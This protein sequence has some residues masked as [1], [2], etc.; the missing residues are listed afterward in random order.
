MLVKIALA[1]SKK[2]LLTILMA[3]LNQ[4]LHLADFSFRL[5][6][7]PRLIRIKSLI[8]HSNTKEKIVPLQISGPLARERSLLD[9]KL[10][11]HLYI[12]LS[13]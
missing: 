7:E 10:Y 13:L 8:L 3:G 5:S 6:Y 9:D 11:E 12:I 1:L 4:T 2:I